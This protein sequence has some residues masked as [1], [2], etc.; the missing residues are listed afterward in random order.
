[1][2]LRILYLGGKIYLRDIFKGDLVLSFIKKCFHGAAVDHSSYSIELIHKKH[3]TLFKNLNSFI[4]SKVNPWQ[5]LKLIFP[6]LKFSLLTPFSDSTKKTTTLQFLLESLVEDS[7]ISALQNFS[8]DN[9]L[10]ILMPVQ[11][12]SFA[13]DVLLLLL[14][15]RGKNLPL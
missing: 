1:M 5:Q 11:V 10:K 8:Y 2:I 4:G 7:G 15:L 6:M 3:H 14:Q 9:F 13:H 12:F